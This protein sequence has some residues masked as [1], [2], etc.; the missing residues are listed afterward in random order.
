MYY[1]EE[2]VIFYNG[3]FVKAKEAS[4]STYGQTLHYGNGVFEGIRSY[5]TTEGTKIFKSKEHYERLKF[6]VEVMDIDFDYSVEELTEITYELL[7]R[8]NVSDA[9]IRPIVL[10]GEN[11]GVFSAKGSDLIIQ[12]WEWGKLMGDKLLRVKTSKFQR[13]NPKSCFVEAKVTG[14]YVNSILASN[15]VKKVG[16]DEALLLDMNNNVAECSGANI[17]M[18]RTG[19]LYTPPR[20]HIMAGI[21]RATIIELCKEEGIPVHEKHFTLD[22]LKYAD[23]AFFTGTAAEVV[24]LQSIDEYEFPLD[25]EKSQGQ[26]LMKLYKQEVLGLREKCLTN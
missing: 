13:P 7:R 20:G 26:K 12:C 16:F 2:S 1:K 23:S 22:E 11:M 17:F 24:G 8:N 5:G 10:T 18:E 14:H 6:G 3:E 15:E 21:T 9:Y 4:T 19:V 25:W